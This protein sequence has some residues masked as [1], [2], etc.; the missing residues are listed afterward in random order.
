MTSHAQDPMVVAEVQDARTQTWDTVSH[1]ERLQT[2]FN[3]DF[4]QP[5]VLII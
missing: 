2:N 1:T 3:P 5:L 4:L